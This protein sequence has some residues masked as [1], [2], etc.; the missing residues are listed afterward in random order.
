MVIVAKTGKSI[1]TL[2]GVTEELSADLE[3]AEYITYINNTD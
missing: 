2:N 3:S 1:N